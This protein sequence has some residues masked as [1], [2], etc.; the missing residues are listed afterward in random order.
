MNLQNLVFRHIEMSAK[1][2]SMSFAEASACKLYA[3]GVAER[4][5]ELH[6]RGKGP[7]VPDL[8]H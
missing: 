2:K 4:S 1:G 6:R 5:Q 8:F 7:F 3:A